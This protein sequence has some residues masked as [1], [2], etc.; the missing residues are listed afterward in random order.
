MESTPLTFQSLLEPGGPSFMPM[1]I[2]VVP[3]SVVEDLGGKTVRRVIST[4]NG[5]TFRLGL[6]PMKTGERYLMISKEIR[7]QIGIQLGAQVTVTLLPD[8][9]PD[10]VDLPLELAQA[11][12]EWP[13]AEAGF[14]RLKPSM[15]RAV[16]QHIRSA[17]RP[18]TRAER[19]VKVLHLLAAGQHPFGATSRD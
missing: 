1:S 12:A 16:A 3:L 17:V 15:K 14:L 2:L 13:E 5:H 7:N 6:H 18:E 4:L 8:P 19:I 9:E 11:L 10:A